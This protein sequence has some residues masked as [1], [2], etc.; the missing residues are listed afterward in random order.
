[1]KKNNTFRPHMHLISQL[2][3]SQIIAQNKAGKTHGA[4][5]FL[6]TN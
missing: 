5:L 6:F 2:L 3:S 4:K 1:M